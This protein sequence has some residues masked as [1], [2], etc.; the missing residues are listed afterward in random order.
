MGVGSAFLE[1][2]WWLMRKKYRD[3]LKVGKLM[4]CIGSIGKVV[5]CL[6]GVLIAKEPLIS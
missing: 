5:P 1:I 3:E 4:C 6:L 2:Q